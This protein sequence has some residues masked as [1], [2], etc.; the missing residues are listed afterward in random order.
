MDFSLIQG[1][2]QRLRDVI[3][4]DN[5]AEPTGPVG[6]IQRQTHGDRLRSSAL[7]S[8]STAAFEP[9]YWVGSETFGQLF[10]GAVVTRRS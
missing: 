9:H 1:P 4:S 10:F 7:I 5:L 8:G 2:G 6:S 3:L